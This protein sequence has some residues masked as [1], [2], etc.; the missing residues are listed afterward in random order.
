MLPA[1][2]KSL[3]NVLDCKSLVWRAK[4]YDTICSSVK[5][6]AEVVRTGL[7]RPDERLDEERQVS[8]TK[9]LDIEREGETDVR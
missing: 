6:G 1:F 3:G 4:E 5:P 9:L 2:G 8:S 7:S